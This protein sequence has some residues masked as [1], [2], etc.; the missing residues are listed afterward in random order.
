MGPVSVLRD[1]NGAKIMDLETADLSKLHE[2]GWKMPETFVTRAA[3]GITDLYGNLYKPFDF[4]PN[5]KYPI[6]AT[7][8]PARKPN[9]RRTTSSTGAP[10]QQLAQLGFIVIQVGNRG[11]TPLRSKVYQ[12]TATATCAITAS[13]TR[14]VDRAT[15]GP[16]CV[17]R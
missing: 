15:R 11:G 5:R 6:I 12:A 4:D 14:N 2:V 9:R 16:P 10:R 1:A 17:D 13:P 3:D 7:C 8:I